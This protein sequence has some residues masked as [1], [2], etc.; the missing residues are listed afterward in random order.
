MGKQP[1][2][3]APNSPQTMRIEVAVLRK[4]FETLDIDKD[5]FITRQ[6]FCTMCRDIKLPVTP[7]E[8]NVLFASG[9]ASLLSVLDIL[10]DRNDTTLVGDP[11]PQKKGRQEVN[12]KEVASRTDHGQNNQP[13]LIKVVS[14]DLKSIEERELE[15]RKGLSLFGKIKQMLFPHKE[16]DRFEAIK[17]PFRLVRSAVY[18]DMTAPLAHYFISSGHNS[19]LTGNQMTS[20]SS[21]KPISDALLRGC[22]VIELDVWSGKTEPRVLHGHT[23]TKSVSFQ[24]CVRAIKATAFKNSQYP[25]II[26]IE[27]HC[28]TQ[29][30]KWMAKILNEELGDLIYRNTASKTWS[31]FPSPKALLKKILIRDKEVDVPD[32]KEMLE[33]ETSQA[34]KTKSEMNQRA[35]RQQMWD[36]LKKEEAEGQATDPEELSSMISIVNVKFPVA[37]ASKKAV[38]SSLGESTMESM[39]QDQSRII[40]HTQKHLLRTYPAGRRVDSS[41]YDPWMMWSVGTQIAALNWQGHGAPMW[42]NQGMFS[43]NGGIGYIKKPGWMLAGT[44]PAPLDE[45][46]VTTQLKIEILSARHMRHNRVRN[47]CVVVEVFGIP[48]DCKSERT[49]S[50]KAFDKCTWEQTFEF[51]LR[52]PEMAVVL[53]TLIDEETW[54][55]N[56]C[57]FFSFPV[58][59]IPRGRFQVQLLN[60]DGSPHKGD[61][62]HMTLVFGVQ[63]TSLTSSS[64]A[65]KGSITPENSR[66]LETVAAKKRVTSDSSGKDSTDENKR[67]TSQPQQPQGRRPS[68]SLSATGTTP[69]QS[70]PKPRPT[71]TANQEP[72]IILQLEPKKKK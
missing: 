37:D 51:Q 36:Q 9:K 23:M 41:N 39:L 4:Q 5:G 8:K 50:V 61:Q 45:F 22:R 70:S 38:S 31:Q 35:K 57:G 54:N 63:T 2:P 58:N 55:D 6:Q 33:A 21:T 47:N 24:K 3:P 48:L 49:P 52:C 13:K 19:Y 42:V 11:E 26:T 17:T 27:N 59:N 12:L 10:R 53:F 15:A 46:P 44:P 1:P 62:R 20:P 56:F 18:Q 25:V 29:N 64:G 68:S 60:K 43:D 72:P 69:T 7:Q 16:E 67:I 66:A 71:S 32:T 65:R 30:K 34:P 14:M 40:I 28:N